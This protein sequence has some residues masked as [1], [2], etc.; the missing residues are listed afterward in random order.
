MKP[1]CMKNTRKAAMRVQAVFRPLTVFVSWSCISS[2]LGSDAAC[3][4]VPTIH[5]PSEIM[6][7]IAT[8][9]PISFPVRKATKKR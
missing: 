1:A 7:Y 2:A 8:I 9:T 5:G 3:A 4:N 6:A